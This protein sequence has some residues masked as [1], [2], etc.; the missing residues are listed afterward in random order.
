LPFQDGSV[1]VKRVDKKRK[2][3]EKKKA[4]AKPQASYSGFV[5]V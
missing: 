4:A 5:K 1:D 3:E 2:K